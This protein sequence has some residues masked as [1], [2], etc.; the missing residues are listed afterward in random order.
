MEIKQ[1]VATKDAD[2]T[3]S[4]VLHFSLKCL[5]QATKVRCHVLGVSILPLSWILELL[6][7]C[8][9]FCILFYSNVLCCCLCVCLALRNNSETLYLCC[10]LY[11]LHICVL[12]RV[13]C[14]SWF[15]STGYWIG[16]PHQWGCQ[17][18]IRIALRWTIVGRDGSMGGPL[19]WKNYD[20]L[21]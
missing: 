12:L 1:K 4:I 21:A 10:I 7:Q 13:V 8:G 18:I 3:I 9:I 19:N 15:V 5:Y 20:F 14:Q 11:K 6:I 16:G 2:K 17:V